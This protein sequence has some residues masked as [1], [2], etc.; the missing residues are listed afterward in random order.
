MIRPERAL[1]RDHPQAPRQARQRT[2]PDLPTS[3]RPKARRDTG[4]RPTSVLV[5]LVGSSSSA[6]IHTFHLSSNALYNFRK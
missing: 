5:L 1:P 6:L 3:P 4:G 2:A